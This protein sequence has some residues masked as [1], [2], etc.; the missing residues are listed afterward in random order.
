MILLLVLAMFSLLGVLVETTFKA[1]LIVGVGAT[2]FAY[3]TNPTDESLKTHIKSETPT[4]FGSEMVKDVVLNACT[5][6]NI[7]DYKVCKVATI[8]IVG[9]SR[10][11]FI[12]AFSNWV[13]ITK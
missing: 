5:T 2:L 13:C 6:N 8:N 4:F 11:K 9:G 12:G 3:S 10:V 1:A 7:K